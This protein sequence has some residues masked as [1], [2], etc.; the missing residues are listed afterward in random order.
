MEDFGP[1]LRARFHHEA[2]R[3]CLSCGKPFPSEGNWNRI[4]PKCKYLQERRQGPAI[5]HRVF[6]RETTDD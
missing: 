5:A 6:A 3:K 4:C 2:M 1:R